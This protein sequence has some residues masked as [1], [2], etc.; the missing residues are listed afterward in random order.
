MKQAE[1]LY[2]CYGAQHRLEFAKV[3]RQETTD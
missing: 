1:Q 2:A 3:Y